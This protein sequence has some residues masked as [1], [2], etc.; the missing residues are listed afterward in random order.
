MLLTGCTVNMLK[1]NQ[2]SYSVN[3]G[4]YTTPITVAINKPDGNDISIYYTVDG[5]DPTVNSIKYDF[6]ITIS[7]NTNLKSIAVNKIGV[8]S[9]IKTAVYTIS[10]PSD[11]MPIPQTPAVTNNGNDDVTFMN[12]IYGT[13]V[14]Y[15]EG[16]TVSYSFYPI[17]STS[18]MLDCLEVSPDGT[19]DGFSAY[20]T[21]TPIGG[22]DKGTVNMTNI[23]EG[24]IMPLST[25]LNIDCY[26]YNDNQIYIDSYPY[27]YEFIQ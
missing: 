2:P 23:T 14:A 26:P 8:K 1:I 21:I 15:A 6:P 13:W 22:G 19:G 4:T 18:G 9:Q 20:Y 16:W 17:D 5:S 3:E 7:T 12:N 11:Y 25:V 24:G 27:T 10:I